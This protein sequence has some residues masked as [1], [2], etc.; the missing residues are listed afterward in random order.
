MIIVVTWYADGSGGP[1]VSFYPQGG[2]QVADLAMHLASL[3]DTSKSI[4][5]Y[6]V[7]SLTESP[8]MLYP[9]DKRLPF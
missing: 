7:K 3:S 2:D 8:V 9:E 4:L 1:E 6:K 5:V